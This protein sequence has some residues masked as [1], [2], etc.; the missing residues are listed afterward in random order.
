MLSTGNEETSHGNNSMHKYEN[1]C[2]GVIWECSDARAKD[3]VLGE[4]LLVDE[5]A[6]KFPSGG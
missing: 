2:Y 6:R 3:C 1:A 5:I 4:V